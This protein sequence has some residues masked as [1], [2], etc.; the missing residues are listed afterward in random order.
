MSE[1]NA[2]GSRLW[3]KTPLAILAEGAGGGVVVEGSRIVERVAA[4]AKPSSSVDETFDASRHVVIPGLVNTHHHFFQT[5]T[6]AHPLAINKPLFPWLKSLYSVWHRLTPEA[7]RLASR[8]AYAELLL[9]GCTTAGDHHYLFPK[10]L[11]SSVDIQVEEAKALG[12][13]AFVTRGSMSLSERDGGLPPDTLVQDDDTVLSDSERVLSLFHD[14]SP[15]AMVQIGLAPCSPFNVTKRLM[16]ES[17]ALADRYDCRLHTHLGE[18]LDEDA[19]CL[20]A[21]GQRPVD[22]LEEVGWMNA[23]AWLAHGIHFNDEEVVRLGKAGVGVC[24]CPTSNM[25]LASGCCR[26][27]ELEAAGSPVGLGVDGSASNDNSNLMEG[28]RH[29]LMLNRLTYGAEKVTHLDALRWATEGSA[30]CLGR[31]DIGRIEEGREADLAL[32]TLDELRFSGGHDPLATL[33]LCGAYRADRVMVAGQWRVIDGHPIGL[34]TRRLR[35]EH[36]R[37]ALSLFGTS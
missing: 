21:F 7:F 24:H 30:A 26:T 9:S 12:I 28:V 18:T 16:R 1:H 4:S 2:K 3:I 34:D 5:L 25:T 20:E 19:Y 27:C 22:Y 10:G 37:L 35:E 23:R 31:S 15:G 33:V 11:E 6:R 17:A 36:S 14:P 8:L 32:F 13:R 29:A